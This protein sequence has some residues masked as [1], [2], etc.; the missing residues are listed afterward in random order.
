M[1]REF[2]TVFSELSIYPFIQEI[3]SFIY[4]IDSR[5]HKKRFESIFINTSES[6]NISSEDRLRLE[7]TDFR[8]NNLREKDISKILL[9]FSNDSKLTGSL[10]NQYVT[11]IRYII[12]RLKN[13]DSIYSDYIPKNWKLD[14][15]NRSAYKTYIQN[16][17]MYIHQDLF[18]LNPT[19]KGYH[20]YTDTYLFS[21]I[22]DYISPFL[23]DLEKLHITHVS[24]IDTTLLL[25]VSRYILMFILHKLIEFN[26]KVKEE[27][28]EVISLLERYIDADVELNI[29][30]IA[31]TTEL[32]IIDLIT[33]ILQ[34]HYDSKW[35]VSNINVDD[36]M[37]RLSKQR[38][39]EKQ[40][41]IHKLD[42][43]TD[44]KR[45]ATMELQ[46]TGQSNWFKTSG[47]ENVQ[48]VIDEYTNAPDDERYS[49]FNN[50][51]S[52]DNVADAVR[53]IYSGELDTD[54]H[55]QPVT[56]VEE[57]GYMD[58]NDI[59]EDGQMG[60]ELHEFNDEDS[61]DNEFHE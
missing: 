23:S 52:E 48:R 3:S 44:E 10:V 2:E 26:T 18:K 20:N 49:M 4:H 27:D 50:L 53:N 19:Y 41:F 38:E 33:D 12:S 30:T 24:M 17:S 39:K 37:K 36:L 32:F 6:I 61:L 59:D 46:N 42:T 55:N 13:D 54:L 25:I 58:S 31:S 11:H 47:E 56:P 5:N 35:I 8:Y 14:E 45:L 22:Y 29:P 51:L 15:T 40:T 1:K 34:I 16:N 21:A 43:M 28:E 7:G 9:L 57:E 60:D